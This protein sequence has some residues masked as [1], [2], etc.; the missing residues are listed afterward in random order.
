MLE[1]MNDFPD[2]EKQQINEICE[3]I[4]EVLVG[5]KSPDTLTKEGTL[6]LRLKKL[7]ALGSAIAS[8]CERDVVASRVTGCLEAC[9]TR[10]EVKEVLRQAILMAEIPAETYTRI[11]HDAIDAF[12]SQH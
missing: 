5:I 10:D 4:R 8:Q 2:Q 3:L 1:N 12:E 11:V 9:A 7:I 6:G